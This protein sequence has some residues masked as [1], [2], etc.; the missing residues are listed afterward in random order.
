MNL[1]F[2]GAIS[3]MT[4]ALAVDEAKH[5]VRVNTFSPGNVWTPLWEDIVNTSGDPKGIRTAGDDAQVSTMTCIIL[6]L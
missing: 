3:A 6:I 1:L 2:Q 4:R 5:N